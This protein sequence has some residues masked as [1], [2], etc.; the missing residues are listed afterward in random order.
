MPEVQELLE[1]YSGLMPKNNAIIHGPS[2]SFVYISF[3]ETIMSAGQSSLTYHGVEILER[4]TT[5]P[6]QNDKPQGQ[7]QLIVI[8]KLHRFALKDDLTKITK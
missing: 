7:P 1:S 3:F 6:L 8:F 4:H 2:V 5:S